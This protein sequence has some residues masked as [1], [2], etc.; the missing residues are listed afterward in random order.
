MAEGLKIE[1]ENGATYE[2]FLNSP[3]PDRIKEWLTKK[4]IPFTEIL[5]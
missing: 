3:I 2:L 5:N 1:Q 4:G